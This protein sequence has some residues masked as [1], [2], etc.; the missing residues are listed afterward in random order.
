MNGGPSMASASRPAAGQG[1]LCEVAGRPKRRKSLPEPIEWPGG[2]KPWE[3][4]DQADTDLGYQYR[5]VTP[6]RAVEIR[7]EIE[8]G[9]R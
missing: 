7:R 5:W 2:I 1:A 3:P 8:H 4:V 6:R 9:D